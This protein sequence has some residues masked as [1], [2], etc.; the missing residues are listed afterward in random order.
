MT[1][2]EFLQQYFTE[3]DI[4][5]SPE[6][7]KFYGGISQAM[8]GFAQLHVE[9]ALKAASEEAKLCWKNESHPKGYPYFAWNPSGEKN[10][11]DL[12]T[13]IDR[14]GILKAYPKEKIT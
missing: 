7:E 2:E 13:H 1:A 9:E 14:E 3:Y 11:G 10:N 12:A 4:P 5:W 8:I 6:A